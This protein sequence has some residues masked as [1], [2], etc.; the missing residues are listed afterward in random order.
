[1]EQ[2]LKALKSLERIIESLSSKDLARYISFAPLSPD[3]LAQ[4]EN[5]IL[6]YKNLYPEWNLFVDEFKDK[7]IY[8]IE[9]LAHTLLSKYSI[10]PEVIKDPVCAGNCIIYWIDRLN[11]VVIERNQLR[12]KYETK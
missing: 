5:A 4:L 10:D 3:R 1:M 2:G 12:E 8:D 6:N 11:E 9:E 7:I